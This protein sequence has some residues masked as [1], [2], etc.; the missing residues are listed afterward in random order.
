MGLVESKSAVSDE[1]FKLNVE[2]R[3]SNHEFWIFLYGRVVGRFHE[4][5]G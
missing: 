5:T 2:R 3:T 1:S 4:P